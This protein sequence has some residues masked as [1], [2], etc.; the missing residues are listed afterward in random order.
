MSKQAF[1]DTVERYKDAVELADFMDESKAPKNPYRTIL[2]EHKEI[3]KEI[4]KADREDMKK[5][6]AQVFLLT[7]QSLS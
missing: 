3:V 1:Y 7:Q 5:K 6:Q 2:S 4:T